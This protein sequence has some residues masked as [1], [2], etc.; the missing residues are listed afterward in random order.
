MRV[1]LVALAVL[2]TAAACGKPE[3]KR[4]KPLPPGEAAQALHERLWLDRAPRTMNEKFH[5]AVF[6]DGGAAIV[7]HRSVWKGDFELF[8]HEVDGREL[9]FFLP[10]SG[11]EMRSAF[12][13]EPVT[14]QGEAD[15]RL[16]IEHPPL[17][18]HVYLGFP[19]DGAAATVE[20][21]DA[22]LAARFPAK[23]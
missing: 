13:I 10:A 5:V 15:L 8:F 6:T 3:A 2:S 7:Q 16:V 12:R 23:R 20:A 22:W 9:E 17:G 21:V 1:A 18:P 14:G 4:G 11:T 19:A